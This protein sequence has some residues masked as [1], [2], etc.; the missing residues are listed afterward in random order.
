M[1]FSD[2]YIIT[3]HTNDMVDDTN[4]PKKNFVLS[5]TASTLTAATSTSTLS[6]DDVSLPTTTNPKRLLQIPCGLLP[7][8]KTIDP[9]L[10]IWTVHKFINQ[11][12]TVSTMN[13]DAVQRSGFLKWSIHPRIG[14]TM[15]EGTMSKDLADETVLGRIPAGSFLVSL[16]GQA[17]V[18]SPETFIVRNKN[19]GGFFSFLKSDKKTS[20]DVDEGIVHSQS[21]DFVL[22]SAFLR[23]L[24]A[25]FD[26]NEQ[27]LL[28]QVG[29]ENNMSDRPAE[30][31][32]KTLVRVPFIELRG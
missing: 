17:I 3:S 8:S 23:E 12:R 15:L 2:D 6:D 19:A 11:E 27:E 9:Q 24:E 26:Y 22:G 13:F 25:E 5:P 30:P 18:P 10:P 7:F 32:G 31:W 14:K 29:K 4:D 1:K 28:L 16:G 21:L 20:D